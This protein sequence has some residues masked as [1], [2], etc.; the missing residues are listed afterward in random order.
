L[1]QVVALGKQQHRLESQQEFPSQEL[2]ATNKPPYLDRHV[3]KLE[4]ARTRT[5]PEVLYS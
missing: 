3:S 5:A 4:A 1:H 2:L